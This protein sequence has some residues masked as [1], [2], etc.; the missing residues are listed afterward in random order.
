MDAYNGKKGNSKDRSAIISTLNSMFGSLYESISKSMVGTF[1]SSHSSLDDKYSSSLTSKLLGDDVKGSKRVDARFEESSAVAVFRRLKKSIL[2]SDMM[3]AV[4]FLVLSV[5]FV[6]IA[7]VIKD[8]VSNSLV[9]VKTFA[10]LLVIILFAVPSLLAGFA[11]RYRSLGE[12]ISE[13]KLLQIFFNDILGVGDEYYY[14]YKRSPI[15]RASE[16]VLLALIIGVISYFVS[17]VYILVAVLL[18]LFALLVASIP[19][20]GVMAV[21]FFLPFSGMLAQAEAVMISFALITEISVLV[22]ISRGKRRLHIGAVDAFVLLFAVFMLFG[23]ISVAGGIEAFLTSLKYVVI[24]LFYFPIKCVMCDVDRI[25]SCF[26]LMVSSGLIVSV[27]SLFSGIVGAISGDAYISL[28]GMPYDGRL[29]FPFETSTELGVFL[30]VTAVMCFGVFGQSE[31]RSTH[32]RRAALCISA[33][34]CVGTVLTYSA[35]ATVSL[36]IGLLIFLLLRSHKTLTVIMIAAAPTVLL[37]VTVFPMLGSAS[38][39]SYYEVEARA[40]LASLYRG[41]TWESVFALIRDNWFA[42]VGTASFDKYYPQYAVSGTEGSANC[43]SLYLDIFA[44][45][46]IFGFVIFVILIFTNIRAGFEFVRCS[47]NKALTVGAKCT[48]SAVL[49]LCIS[50]FACSIWHDVRLML[51]FWIVL[52]LMG[53]ILDVGYRRAEEEKSQLLFD[54]NAVDMRLYM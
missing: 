35:T 37:L 38:G 53:S 34:I 11:N 1:L 7:N 33:I 18:V 2:R 14:E 20:A 5:F 50:A 4:L 23:G 12:L 13:S 30:A 24:I 28:F 39:S 44:R 29:K 45:L 43:G 21:V 31:T 25:Y 26:A 46:G 8:T 6:F 51:V 27:L 54:E 36:I 17:P 52:S 22:K 19:E 9:L 40:A 47:D 48:L 32:F 16:A 42:G 15:S 49:M 10:D 3:S 41:S